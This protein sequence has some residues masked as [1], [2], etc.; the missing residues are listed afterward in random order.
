MN[1]IDR[2]IA[3][4]GKSLPRKNRADIENEIRSALQDMLDERSRKTG[5]PIDDGM[6]VEALREYGAP[7]KVA[8]SYQPERYIIGP[9]LF[10]SFVTVVKVVLPIVMAVSLVKLGISLGQIQATFENTF[11]T[12]FLAAAEFLGSAFTALGSILVLFLILHATLPE[13]R[14]KDEKWDPLKLPLATSRD[15]VEIGSLILEIFGSALAI[16]VFNFFPQVVSIGRTAWGTWTIG[17]LAIASDK[18]WS[19]TILSEAFFGYLPVLTSLWALTLLLDI[20]LLR[21][22][23]WENWSRWTAFGLKAV[24]VAL[25][26]AMLAGPALIAVEAERMIAAGFPSGLASRLLVNFFEQGIVVVLI[27]TIIGSLVTAARLLVRLTGR[28]LP[29]ALEKF[30]HP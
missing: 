23:R 26:A 5:R 3:E 29:P 11:E 17:F 8:A 25:A 30:A 19:T 13:F 7:A 12:V 1:L 14:S 4:V 21:R 10:P 9:R 20:A 16:V 2:Y 6:I 15:R 27:L 24:T 18:A 28:D 22:G